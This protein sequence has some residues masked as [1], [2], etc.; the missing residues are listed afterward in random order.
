MKL[1][2][3]FHGWDWGCSFGSLPSAALTLTSRRLSGRSWFQPASLQ[4][5]VAF[6]ELCFLFSFF[7]PFLLPGICFFCF[8]FGL[9]FCFLQLYSR[10]IFARLP[11]FFSG[12]PSNKTTITL[13]RE[14]GLGPP[15]QKVHC[16]SPH[17]LKHTLKHTQLLISLA[18]D[19][20]HCPEVWQEKTSGSNSSSDWRLSKHEVSGETVE[21]VPDRSHLRFVFSRLRGETHLFVMFWLV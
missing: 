1:H 14:T 15:P 18:N 6:E 2:K 12:S 4:T 11:A 9:F 8:L 10:L 3:G 7:L 19:L 20:Q 13:Q 16:T 5:W 17:T 21:V